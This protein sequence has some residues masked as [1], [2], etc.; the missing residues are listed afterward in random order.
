MPRSTPAR[1]ALAA[2]W[3]FAAWTL[4]SAAWAES[5]AAAWEGGARTCLYAALLSI[6]LA[7]LP[8]RRQRAWLGAAL[9][10]GVAVIAAIT[11]IDLLRDG[12]DAFL[13]GRLNDPVGY[14]NGTAALF[15]FAFWPLIGFAAPQG[16]AP[17]LR[18]F[19]LSTAVLML[20][21]AFLTQSRG[22]LIGLLAG[23]VVLLASGPD[24]LRRAWLGLATGG[25]VALA[26][27]KL[28]GPYDAFEAGNAVTA[29]E[30][31]SAVRALVLVSLAMFVGGLAFAV[32]DNGLRSSS[33]AYSR[34]RGIA[35]G[36]LVVVVVVGAVGAL[37][38][39]GN[40][41]SYADSELDEFTDVEREASTSSTRLG[42]VGGQR[43]D[44]WRVAWTEFEH[45]P[46]G[47]VGEGNYWF[48]YFRERENDR[49]LS[50]PHSLPF[51]LLAESGLVG[52]ALFATFVVALGIA[53]TQRIRAAP[54]AERRWLAGLAAG[55]TTVLA[56]T[57]TDWFWLLPGLLGLG[58]L[59]LALAGA[60][61]PDEA[62]GRD[63]N[64]AVESGRKSWRGRGGIARAVGAL[65]L[66]GLIASI[67]T[68]YLSDLY[69]RKAR[70]E[71][72]GDP[73]AQLNAARSAEDLNPVSVTPLYLQASAFESMGQL[74]QALEALQVALDQEPRNFVTL[75]LLG[76]FEVRARRPAAAR[77]YYR[78]A[79]SLNPRDVGLQQLSGGAAQRANTTKAI[80]GP[81]SFDASNAACPTPDPCSAFPIYRELG[82]DVYQF[83]LWFSQIAPTPPADPRN[84]NDPAYKW[85]ASADAIVR[86]AAANGIQPAALIQLSPPWANGTSRFERKCRTT[87]HACR[88][89]V[90]AP[91]PTAF[92]DFAYAASRRYPSI[93]LWMIWGEPMLGNNFQ[94]MPPRS[95][96]GPRTYGKILDKTYVA[97]KQASP[98]NLVAGGSTVT[99]QPPNVGF[100]GSPVAFIKSMRLKNGRM[101]RMDLLSHNPFEA[102]F[103]NLRKTPISRGY[104]GLSDID[105]LH[106]DLLKIYGKRVKVP[107]L[108]L[109][110]YTVV[111]DQPQFGGFFISRK[112]QARWL[113]AAYA[114]A[115]SQKYVAGLGW[116]TL[117][118]QPK[119]PGSGNHGLM[120]R[121][122]VRKPSFF[123]YAAV[124]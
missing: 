12:T 50:D 116:F 2:I 120:Q 33:E 42:S 119:G 16:R 39:I 101:P 124:P 104:G 17:A 74:D 52:T 94:P 18:A 34:L 83:Q 14:R 111:S 62:P 37:I 24:R 118:D 123:A 91:D 8:D 114:I 97:L 6:G 121:D 51:R 70:A 65:A 81:S 92:A 43:Y 29:S 90:S 9:V 64:L 56:Q 93:K 1:I 75:G 46:I 109:S 85:P 87:F 84:P 40:P 32:F 108:W 57:V 73:E 7:A 117:L 69:V 107:K 88:S 19:A 53:I 106:R 13:A 27:A 68:L 44:L 63:R 26:S 31:D 21:L 41:V 99:Q 112:E 72:S 96:L 47:G 54:P 55:G 110:E 113:S 105:S 5:A 11:L 103:P 67:T 20:G 80:W 89:V 38:A 60:E 102:R 79:L 28:L 58:F 95:K 3:G 76:D 122:G 25:A 78:R 36:G 115:G 100:G 82:V 4:L 59:V 23:A 49:N 98:L 15:A 35:L 30:I 10:A 22:V 45:H 66:L 77:A 48:D 61:N 71:A 86:E